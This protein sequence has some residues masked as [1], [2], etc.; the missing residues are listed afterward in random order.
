MVIWH[1]NFIGALPKYWPF[2]VLF[3]WIA[4]VMGSV[5]VSSSSCLCHFLSSPKIA[6]IQSPDPPPPP[7]ATQ[8][9]GKG[10]PN[11]I[12]STYYA[13]MLP[14]SSLRYYIHSSLFPCQIV[15]CH[16]RLSIF[17]KSFSSKPWLDLNPTRSCVNIII[18]MQQLPPSS[19][20]DIGMPQLIQ[21]SS[22]LRHILIA[23]LHQLG[24]A[25]FRINKSYGA[26]MR[27]HQSQLNCS[28]IIRC[29]HSN[30]VRHLH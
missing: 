18:N 26:K 20:L 7:T 30:T 24:F 25:R 14:G 15:V 11:V 22:A 28:E 3:L 19:A 21:A 13:L 23:L 8:G 10:I 2:R 5:P 1:V 4:V 9:K 29:R 6:A 16:S 27:Q 12:S 17:N